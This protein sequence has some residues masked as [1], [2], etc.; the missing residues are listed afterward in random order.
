MKDLSA[1]ARGSFLSD[2]PGT[3][4]PMATIT[5]NID[6]DP[7]EAA[8]QTS[9]DTLLEPGDPR[10]AEAKINFVLLVLDVIAI[11]YVDLRVNSR[12]V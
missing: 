8:S 5:T 12:C 6:D 9:S 4:L 2:A 11:D 3:A 10:E 7:Q 1:R